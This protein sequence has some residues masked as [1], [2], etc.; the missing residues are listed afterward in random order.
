VS[1][2]LAAAANLAVFPYAASAT[3]FGYVPTHAFA[4]SLTLTFFARDLLIAVGTC[5]WLRAATH[6]LGER[7]P[8]AP[9]SV[10]TS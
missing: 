7:A 4:V 5:V 6:G 1:W 10:L 8:E 3:H 2:L 9:T